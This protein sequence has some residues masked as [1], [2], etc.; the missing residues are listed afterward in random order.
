MS[1]LASLLSNRF[2]DCNIPSNENLC[3]SYTALHFA[4]ENDHVECVNLLLAQKSIN[5]N[6]QDSRDRTPLHYAAHHGYV[7]CV[8]ALLSHKDTTVNIQ[9]QS[10]WTP[11][12]F[13]CRSG[14]VDC[15]KTLL[16]HPEINVN[17]C[18]SGGRTPLSSTN[19]CADETRRKEIQQLL[20]EHGATN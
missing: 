8:K 14:R 6:A 9:S 13:A 19:Y 16:A 4:V 15:V 11:L 5:V 2:I 17:L 12:H 18:T 7:E 3:N 10:G 20:L 1:S